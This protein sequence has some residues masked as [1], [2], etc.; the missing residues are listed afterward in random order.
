VI[1]AIRDDLARI[2]R[3]GGGSVAPLETAATNLRFVTEGHLTHHL[4]SV[5]TMVVE[6]DGESSIGLEEARTRAFLLDLHELLLGS[7][8]RH[9]PT[10]SAGPD[11]DEE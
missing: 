9:P 2:V 4:T 3:S 6:R 11:L 8:D 1:T 10:E 5:A 7:A